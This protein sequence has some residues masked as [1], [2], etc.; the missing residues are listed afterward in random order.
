METLGPNQEIERQLSEYKK[1][2]IV[3]LIYSEESDSPIDLKSELSR[4]SREKDLESAALE[5]LLESSD[6]HTSNPRVQ[7][8]ISNFE[9]RIEEIQADRQM[10]DMFQELNLYHIEG[11]LKLEDR[12][13]EDLLESYRSYKAFFSSIDP[14][15]DTPV[16]KDI[17]AIVSVYNQKIIELLEKTGVEQK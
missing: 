9:S 11:E 1:S 15:V 4:L 3:D 5:K 13:I 16:I 8:Q 14:T 2:E 12:R 10:Y 6:R 17:E 7:K